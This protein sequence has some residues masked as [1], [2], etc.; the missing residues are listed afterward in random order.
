MADNVYRFFY[1]AQWA[2]TPIALILTSMWWKSDEQ[3]LRVAIWVGGAALGTLV[4]QAVDIGA[5]KLHGSFAATPWKWLYV[6]FGTIAMGYGLI[7]LV[8]V[9]PTPLSAWFLSERERA[10]AVHRVAGNKTGIHTGAI[11]RKQLVE[12]FCDPQLYVLCITGFIF[13][14]A[15]VAI[16]T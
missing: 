15:N 10:I 4:G 5:V 12:A 14:F 9:P 11:K 8:L 7:L 13:N 1:G 6:I 16:N 3:P 2:V